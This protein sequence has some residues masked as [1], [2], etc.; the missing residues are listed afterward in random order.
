MV[1]ILN[2][3]YE[4]KKAKLKS[5]IGKEKLMPSPVSFSISFDPAMLLWSF[6]VT[7]A[8]KVQLPFVSI[9]GAV[10]SFMVSSLLG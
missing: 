1:G 4:K 3:F 2:F 6:P 9:F 10:V 7:A 5:R 8:S